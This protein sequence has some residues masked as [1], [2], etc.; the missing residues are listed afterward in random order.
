MSTFWPQKSNPNPQYPQ[1]TI[2]WINMVFSHCYDKQLLHLHS[3]RL[4]Q[5]ARLELKIFLQLSILKSQWC[6]FEGLNQSYPPRKLS[7]II[8]VVINNIITCLLIVSQIQ[9]TL[10]ARNFRLRHNAA[11]RFIVWAAYLCRLLASI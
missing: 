10:Y 8:I 3:T 9:P 5:L 2:M 6:I 7:C 4:S 1:S 11:L